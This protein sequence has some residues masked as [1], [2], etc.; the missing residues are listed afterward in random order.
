MG[1]AV[2]PGNNAFGSYAQVWAGS[3][4]YDAY[5]VLINVNSSNSSTAA[6]DLLVTIG[7]DLA[8]G[9][10]YTD[11]ISDLLCSDAASYTG[12]SNGGHWFRFPVFI[13]RG[14]SVGAKASVNN[15]TVSTCRVNAI[16]YCEPTR[17]DLILIGKGVQTFGADEANSRGTTIVPGDTSEGS[18]T[19]VGSAITR[20]IRHWSF[21]IGANDADL[22][23][24]AIHTDLSVGS[25]GTKRII[26][27]NAWSS[28]SAVEAI[29]KNEASREFRGNVG[30]LVYARQQIGANAAE[31]NHSIIVYGVYT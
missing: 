24:N 14:A 7:L 22:A 29:G 18:W 12:G 27:Q 17:P 11:F 6:R 9:T 10:S 26:L 20:P 31:T 1:V 23:V 25:A 2:T 5:E 30:E 4:T 15:A 21:G 19:Q 3:S 16:F 13:P 28:S 8:G